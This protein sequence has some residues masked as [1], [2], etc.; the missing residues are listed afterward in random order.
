MKRTSVLFF[1]VIL[2]LF[3]SCA[4]KVQKSKVKVSIG[5]SSTIGEDFSGGFLISATNVSS[6]EVLLSKPAPG[7]TAAVFDLDPKDNWDFA[8]IGWN[9]DGGNSTHPMEGNVYCGFKKNQEIVSDGEM[10]LDLQVAINSC[11]SQN[12]VDTS[13]GNALPSVMPQPLQLH[14]CGGIQN[15][16]AEGG[17]IP[18]ALECGPS[19][20]FGMFDGGDR[21]YRV[22]LRRSDDVGGDLIV[23]RCL[24]DSDNDAKVLTNI[25]LPYY[26]ESLK[27][28][29]ESFSST[30][31]IATNKTEVYAFNYGGFY[32]NGESKLSTQMNIAAAVNHD[33]KLQVFLHAKLCQTPAELARRP[34]AAGSSSSMTYL[35]C[36]ENQF[37]YIASG[38]GTCDGSGILA[39]GMGCE[40]NAKYI[41]GRNINFGS[42]N[43]T[44]ANAFSGELDGRGHLLSNGDSPLFNQLLTPVSGEDARIHSFNIDGFNLSINTAVANDHY[45]I[46]AKEIINSNNGKRIEI[47][48]IQLW[49]NNS[50]DFDSTAVTGN[51]Y[52]GGLIGL[53]DFATNGNGDSIFIR[54]VSSHVD[55][56]SNSPQPLAIGGLVGKAVGSANGNQSF[57]LNHVGVSNEDDVFDDIGR[58]DLT[59]LNASHSVGGIVGSIDH[60][61][62]REDNIAITK[63]QGRSKLGGILGESNMNSSIEGS[64]ADVEIVSDGI[65]TVDRAGGLV[66]NITNTSSLIINSSV[67]ELEI[68]DGSVN[69]T[70]IGGLVGSATTNNSSTQALKINNAK[71]I[72]DINVDG[73]AIGG[74]VGHYNPGAYTDGVDSPFITNSVALGSITQQTTTNGNNHSRGGFVGDMYEGRITRSVAWFDFIQGRDAIGGGFGKANAEARIKESRIH[75]QDILADATTG[76]ASRGVGGVVGRFEPAGN[77]TGNYFEEIKVTGSITT[78]SGI[79]NCDNGYCG[80]VVGYIDNT[81]VAYAGYFSNIVHMVSVENDMSVDIVETADKMCGYGGSPTTTCNIDATFIGNLGSNIALDSDANCGGLPG[82]FNDSGATLPCD[83]LFNQKWQDF[84]LRSGASTPEDYIAG[85]RFEPF[86]ISFEG[87]WNAIGA[88]AF[89]LDKWFALQNPIYFSGSFIPIGDDNI[90]QLDGGFRGGI[91]SNGYSLDNITLNTTDINGDSNQDA[92]GLIPIL[93]GGKIGLRDEPLYINNLNLNCNTANCGVVGLAKDG[94]VHTI[95]NGAVNAL[96][97]LGNIAGLVGHVQNGIEISES[98]FEGEIRAA[99]NDHVGAFIGGHT[100]SA[101]ITIEESFVRLSKLEG[102]DYVGGLIGRLDNPD[103]NSR[104]EKT[105]VIHGIAPASSGNNIDGNDEVGGFIGYMTG[106]A[107]VSKTYVSLAGI[108]RS[109]TTFDPYAR[110]GGGINFNGGSDNYIVEAPGDSLATVAPVDDIAD[111]INNISGSLGD[112]FIMSGPYL[113]LEWEVA[114]F[115]H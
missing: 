78:G 56:D 90:A 17:N 42:D 108:S 21:S 48:D 98:G 34:F 58:V 114:G 62:I 109:T 6:G 20:P 55:I 16:I 91:I 59:A 13:I 31:C 107:S 10:D 95:V 83:L 24:N 111:D 87:D 82:M 69:Y 47:Q 54:K 106:A 112:K 2:V 68:N 88:D 44:I 12:G 11:L 100:T 71:A 35:V 86:H 30:G 41:I 99:G 80:S 22:K 77:Q 73:S 19:N 18:G 61:E 57:E 8:A 66:G 27:Y 101:R 63:I 104:I 4:P 3:A 85:N 103:T 74:L 93:D 40:S 52:I 37:N 29:I 97:A 33:N 49:G 89:L 46:L 72:V 9:D 84:N 76:N 79:S 92:G 67:A 25:R 50:I 53:V 96:S 110:D 75:V 51:H 102:N 105:Y 23:S 36:N 7:A 32:G 45:G 94:G 5:A 60:V 39:S 28:E 14:T 64:F 113:F 115:D 70:S 43:T 15:Y 81:T 65:N 1:F 26:T 38:P